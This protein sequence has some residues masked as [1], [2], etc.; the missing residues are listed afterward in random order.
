MAKIVLNEYLNDVVG[1]HNK[2][3]FR[4]LGLRSLDSIFLRNRYSLNLGSRSKK[5]RKKR[6]KK[7]KFS[8]RYSMLDC[9]WKTMTW[10]QKKQFRYFCQRH[11]YFSARRKRDKDIFFQL[12]LKYRLHEFLRE[13]LNLEINI[14]I[15]K[16]EGKKLT[17]QINA[18]GHVET[19]EE[20]IAQRGLIS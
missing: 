17:L 15:V 1:A 6:R 2:A 7:P 11:N 12:G 5:D 10:G 3:T 13:Q 4:K 8:D 9:M 19:W 16:F 18:E 14:Q 20:V